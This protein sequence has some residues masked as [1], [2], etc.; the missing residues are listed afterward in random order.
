LWN[1]W[2]SKSQGRY[3]S[4]LLVFLLCFCKAHAVCEHKV[5]PSLQSIFEKAHISLYTVAGPSARTIA[6]AISQKGPQD[7]LGARYTGYYRWQLSWALKPG[8]AVNIKISSQ[9]VVYL[10]CLKR[11]P[12]ALKRYW[13]RYLRQLVIH[14]K[15]HHQLFSSALNQLQ[16]AV[17]DWTKSHRRIDEIFKKIRQTVVKMRANDRT[18]DAHDHLPPFDSWIRQ[19]RTKKVTTHFSE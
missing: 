14:E 9:S 4:I 17:A 11:A 12:T 2:F 3:L 8:K 16:L 15:M 18:W 5:L 1:F 7:V 6:A 13:R 10:P 19:Q